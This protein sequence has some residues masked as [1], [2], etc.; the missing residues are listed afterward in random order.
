MMDIRKL[1]IDTSSSGGGNGDG[2][3]SSNIIRIL[4]FVLIASS[5]ILVVCSAALCIILYHMRSRTNLFM[6]ALLSSIWIS[7]LVHLL[8]FYLACNIAQGWL[9]CYTNDLSRWVLALVSRLLLLSSEG[10]WC[11]VVMMFEYYLVG[12]HRRRESFFFVMPTITSSMRHLAYSWSE[13]RGNDSN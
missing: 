8:V 11:S 7:T 3:N 5:F 10:G 9:I 12:P 4:S 13:P 2:G 1:L 6:R